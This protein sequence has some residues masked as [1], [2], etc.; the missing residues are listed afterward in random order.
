MIQHL[1]NIE[2]LGVFSNYKKPTGIESFKRYNLIYGLNGSGKTTLS[3]FFADLNKGQADGFPNLKYK[4]ATDEGVFQQGTPYSRKIRVFN[5]EY[6]DANIGQLEGTLNPIYVIGEE[7]KTLAESVKAD[8]T[9]L[10]AL[11]DQLEK[12]TT[13]LDKLRTKKGKLFTDV[14]PKISE[15]A[16]G[17]VTR[18]YNKRNAEKSYTDLSS[19][20][21][22]SIEEL[23]L[24]SVAMKQPTM[25]R[26][27]EFSTP[28]IKIGSSDQPLFD[29]LKRLR[30]VA[31][32]LSNKSATSAAIERLKKDPELA[33]WIELGRDIH[34]QKDEKR[35]EYCLQKIPE[36][37][38]AELAAH[39]NKSDSNLKMEIERAISDVRAVTE[40]V[41]R[42]KVLSEKDLYPELREEFSKSSKSLSEEQARV[43]SNLEAM[44]EA[45]KD[46][47]TRRT[48]SYEAVL[49]ALSSSAWDATL[50]S[51]NSLIQHHNA[52]T[53]NYQ[54]RLDSN[55]AKI[56]A[57]FL[58]GIEREVEDV[59]KEIKNL[60]EEVETCNNG[61]AKRNKLGIR[62]L[63]E[64]IKTNRAKISNSHQAAEDLSQKLATFLGRD[65]LKFEP[66]GEGYRVMR[67]SRAAKRLSEGEKTA[68]TFLYFVVGLKDQ[69]FDLA[70]GIVVID[71][72]ISSLDS[73]SVYQAFSFLKSAV[74]EARQVFLLTHNFE[75]LKLL[76]DWLTYG[77]QRD[78]SY[79]ML[80]CTHTSPS[81][82]ETQ[83]KPLDKVLIENRNEYIYLVR[84]L[85]EFVSDGTIAQ[86]YPIPNIARK[87]L[88]TFL[89]QHSTGKTFFKKLEDLE[90]DEHIKS[91]LYKYTND[92][93]HPT[94]SGLDP[95]LVGET[96]TNIKHLLRM[97]KAVAPVHYKAL[98]GAVT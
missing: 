28:N 13:T 98:T 55:F 97:I 4:I 5:A 37:R 63:D 76:L 29:A 69:D 11:N 17:A 46:K 50:L 78:K 16:K 49:P 30:D 96:Q 71:D 79:W 3:R 91:T 72:P 15:A 9:Q 2:N 62:D 18:T 68:I 14:A 26:V 81:V 57:H 87:V 54:K 89:D 70:E 94:L 51:L 6:V 77:N 86:S 23:A 85:M 43:L 53:E 45:L 93:S 41:E 88:E 24:A 10:A 64:R 27:P 47:L 12:T 80:H 44:E 34:A 32:E 48:E 58:S 67:F 59:S 73:S 1:Q 31:S 75:F 61:D 92:L 84:T 38:E 40:E 65:D 8:E 52:E 21:L 22:L 33:G 74:K 82:R 66:E 39:F 95:A 20:N 90:Y 35:C 25:D 56:E 83:L 19:T 7:N 42:I 60:E 36:E